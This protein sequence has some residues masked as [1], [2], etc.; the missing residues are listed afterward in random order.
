MVKVYSPATL[1]DKLRDKYL[2]QHGYS[3]DEIALINKIIANCETNKRQ[4]TMSPEEKALSDADTLF[5]ALPI[6]P[7]LFGSKYITEN[8]IDIKKLA[9]QII[10]Y[11]KPLFQKNI[12]FYTKLAKRKYLKWARINLMLWDNV[13]ESLSDPE[14]DAVLKDAKKLG[15]I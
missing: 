9:A 12:Y 7:I 11:Q 2:H 14:V 4:K 13:R 6:T 3:K 15:V 1:G 8:N 10:A 5:K